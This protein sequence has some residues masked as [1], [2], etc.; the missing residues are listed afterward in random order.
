MQVKKLIDA[1]G[2]QADVESVRDP[3]TQI[4]AQRL[5]T[6]TQRAQPNSVWQSYRR[7]IAARRSS[8][9]LREGSLE[10]LQPAGDNDALLAFT[11]TAKTESALVLH[12]VDDSELDVDLA[13]LPTDLTP[14]LLD[15]GIT[16]TGTK[17]HLPPHSSAI[18]T[19]PHPI[20]H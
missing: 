17:A 7:W 15:P 2:E 9:A 8:I 11:R 13:S 18:W 10:L 19:S 14:L 1:G 5:A 3:H 6:A 12:N 16:L 20:K 4:A